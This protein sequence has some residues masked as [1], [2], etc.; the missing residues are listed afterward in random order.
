[1]DFQFFSIEE[2]VMNYR[3]GGSLRYHLIFLYATD[4]RQKC[5][6]RLTGA[7]DIHL[8]V[9]LHAGRACAIMDKLPY[10]RRNTAMDIS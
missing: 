10:D 3:K 4:V 2:S 5:A 7:I 1:M 6:I 8:S 9:A